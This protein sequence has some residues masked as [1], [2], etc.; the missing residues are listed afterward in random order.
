MRKGGDFRDNEAAMEDTGARR[1][2]EG[3]ASARI[4]ARIFISNKR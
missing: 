4:S 3:Q 1:A 2:Y